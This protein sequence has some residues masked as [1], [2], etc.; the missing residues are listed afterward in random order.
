MVGHLLDRLVRED[1][2]VGVG[3]GHGCGIVRP[4]WRERRIASLVEDLGPAVPTAR[5]QPETMNE[6]NRRAARRVGLVD[7][8]FVGKMRAARR[9]NR[10]WLSAPGGLGNKQPGKMLEHLAPTALT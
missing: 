10:A 1:V 6:H 9:H 7:L 2:W 3:L 4:A 5:Q 8:L